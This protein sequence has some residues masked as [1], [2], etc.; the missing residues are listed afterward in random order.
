MNMRPRPWGKYGRQLVCHF[1][2]SKDLVAEQ[3]LEIK[4]PYPVKFSKWKRG[5]SLY[6]STTPLDCTLYRP[7]RRH[8]AVPYHGHFQSN[9]L[10][11]HN[12]CDGALNATDKSNLP[13]KGRPSADPI[14]SPVRRYERR[15]LVN[16]SHGGRRPRRRFWCVGSRREKTT[17]STFAVSERN[18]TPGWGRV[19][20]TATTIHTTVTTGGTRNDPSKTTVPHVVCRTPSV[21]TVTA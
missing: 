11:S 9:H 7:T 10:S 21:T 2:Q 12:Y 16:V 14:P 13:R 1:R 5:Q 6:L 4:Y 19:G 15:L 20:H 17:V 18:G 3:R 8:N